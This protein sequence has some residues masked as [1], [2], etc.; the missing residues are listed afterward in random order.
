[1]TSLLW[2]TGASSIAVLD[3]SPFRKRTVLHDIP[4]ETPQP[5]FSGTS[6][7]C[8]ELTSAEAFLDCHAENQRSTSGRTID[9]FMREQNLSY[10]SERV[11]TVEY[12]REWH[13]PD[14]GTMALILGA[15][16]VVLVLGVAGMWTIAGFRKS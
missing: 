15:P 4:I 10:P 1:M 7:A 6:L 3:S 5:R 16:F 14:S 13:R 8:E 11:E 12:V 2:V 9:D